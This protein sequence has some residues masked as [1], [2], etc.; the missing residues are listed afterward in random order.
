MKKICLMLTFVL[1]FVSL[2]MVGC[3]VKED[4]LTK[5]KV[6]EVTHSIF[7]APFY[8]AINN[9]Y[10]TD[11]KIEIE[12]TN[13]GG[14]DASMSAILSGDADI[15]LMGPEASIYVVEGNA[16]DKPV[17]FGQLTKR[18]GSF[19]VAKN[20]YPNFSLSDLIGKEIIGGRRGGVPAMTL[21]YCI[22]Q[23]GL[24]IGTGEN[25][26]NLNTD[27]AFNNTASVFETTSAEFCTLFEP[28]ASELCASKGYHI[29][30]SVGMVS[31]EVPYTCF[32][33]KQSFLEENEYLCE[34]FLRA[35]YRGYKFLLSASV[36][37]M[38]TALSPSFVGISKE[39]IYTSINSYVASDAWVAS[40]AM[41]TD[42]FNRLQDVMQNAGYLEERVNFDSVINNKIAN[43][44][45]DYF[46]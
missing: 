4:T 11:E 38:Y 3:G 45:Y 8:V 9:G 10:F 5:V 6:N 36:D 34:R 40:P 19:I 31:G 23:A 25:K 13:G 30:A 32:Q 16:K 20:D 46:K 14:A 17:V 37:E 41:T 1:A 26:V 39:S 21:E 42:A 2:T 35:V 24:E 12:L 15:G 22:T 18:D 7:Y 44:V 43:K 33:T 27:V 28:T 29:V